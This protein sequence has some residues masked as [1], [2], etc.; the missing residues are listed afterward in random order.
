MSAVD[1]LTNH[2]TSLL[3]KSTMLTP[4]CAFTQE[5]NI[6]VVVQLQNAQAA[7]VG[8]KMPHDWGSCKAMHNQIQSYRGPGFTPVQG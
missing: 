3:D 5:A 4:L 2:M 8:C 7:N 1:R 6:T